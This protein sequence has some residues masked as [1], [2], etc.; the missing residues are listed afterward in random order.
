MLLDAMRM[1]GQAVILAWDEF[2][3][4]VIIDNLT[5]SFRNSWWIPYKIKCLVVTGL[6]A[7]VVTDVASALSLVSADLVA[8]GAFMDTSA[9]MMAVGDVGAA[10]TGTTP[11]ASASQELLS[12]SQIA[13]ANVQTAGLAL[14]STILPAVVSA[15]GLVAAASAASGY[16]GRAMANFALAT[17]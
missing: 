6:G 16:I 2:V 1:S 3:Y 13:A 7:P 11:Y 4:T 5:L 10:S 12:T 9:A 17:E 8:A 15:A 14:G